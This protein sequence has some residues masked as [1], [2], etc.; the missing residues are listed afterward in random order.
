VTISDLQDLINKANRIVFFGGAGVST[1]SGLKDFRSD[2]GLYSSK[3]SNYRPEEILSHSFLM[4]YPEVF[5]DYYKKVFIQGALHVK[6]NAAHKYLAKLESN[7]KNITIITQ[8]IDNLHQIAGSKNVIELHGSIY[9]N[10]SIKTLQRYDGIDI[11]LNSDSVPRT[12]T[13]E[14]IRPDVTLYEEPLDNEVIS[15]A[16][17]AL[18]SG[19]LLIIGG[20]SLT[21]Y[22]AANLINYFEGNNVVAINRDYI[23]IK[24]FIQGNIGEIFSKLK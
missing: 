24:N 8:N 18:K 4:N 22:P 19:D 13:G 23:P 6:P 16:I 9:R 21:V 5:F 15:N 7:G 20:T 3:F 1:E 2:D 14:M 12:N 10:Y 11:I 17:D